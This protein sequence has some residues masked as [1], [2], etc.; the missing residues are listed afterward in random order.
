[1]QTECRYC[2][3]AFAD[4]EAY[5]RHL[6]T[7]HERSELSRLDARLADRHE[8]DPALADERERVRS[9]LDARGRVGSMRL[10]LGRAAVVELTLLALLATVLVGLVL[11]LG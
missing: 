3:A 2:G 8:S 7:A 9:F 10:P 1:M 5:V 6:A 11:A 4:R